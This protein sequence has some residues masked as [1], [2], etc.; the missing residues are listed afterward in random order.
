NP[1]TPLAY[2]PPDLAQEIEIARYILAGATGAFV[3]DILS[4][5]KD[6]YKVIFKTQ[7]SL[8][9]GVYILSRV[10]SFVF[11]FVS[12][13]WKTSP[14]DHCNA[15]EKFVT[16][17][18]L[19]STSTT[20]LLFFLRIRAIFRNNKPVV[21]AFFILW[22]GV[23][24]GSMTVPFALV[25]ENLGPTKYCADAV[26][27]PFAGSIIIVPMIHDTIVFLAISTRLIMNSR[28]ET[29]LQGQ[30]RMFFS[31][32]YLPT[33]SAVLLK[34]GQL[35]YVITVLSN[36][37]VVI[38]FFLQYLPVGYRTMLVMPNTFLTNTMA[39]RIFRNARLKL[40][41]KS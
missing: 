27:K 13:L 20:S 32:R 5:V 15:F 39:C 1:F 40:G 14:V 25:G 41:K 31:G 10:A 36:T 16:S 30:L 8:P 23:L 11:V 28:R 22:L 3:W 21:I 38:F 2:V 18:L 34:D 29:T 37:I 19:V 12:T 24:G 4:N 26:A 7:F 6:E 9:T 35:Y 17:C 33:I